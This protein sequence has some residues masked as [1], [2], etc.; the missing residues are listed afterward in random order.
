MPVTLSEGP[1]RAVVDPDA[2][3]GLLALDLVRSRQSL[4]LV[5]DVHRG[6]SQLRCSSFLMVPYSN[7][8]A[9]GRFTFGGHGYQLAGAERHAIHGDVRGRPWQVLESGPATLACAF[10]SAAHERVNWP[11]PFEARA[12]FQVTGTRLRQSL[13]LWN[14]G[15]V[16]MPAGLGWHPYFNRQL[17][18]ADDEVLIRFRVESEYPDAHGSRIPSGPPGPV[19]PRRRFA[20]ERALAPDN[21]LDTCFYGYDG[22]GWIHWPRSGV[23]LRFACSDACRHLIL[24]NPEGAPHFAVEPVTNANDGVNLLARRE[25]TAGTVVLEPGQALEARF[26]LTVEA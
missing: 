4:A 24:Y 6:R 22:D 17:G 16:P 10:D 2:G 12:E 1:L 15:D 25:P 18:P 23:R 8:I 5:P 20:I 11:W 7:R 14:R 3:C 26:D 9:D 13:A 21:P 19:A